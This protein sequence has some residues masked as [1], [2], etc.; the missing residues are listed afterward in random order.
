[1]IGDFASPAWLLLLPLAALPLLRRRGDVIDYPA[2]DW[3]PGSRKGL[4][5]DRIGRLLAALL[6]AAV[7]VG[8]AAPR[9][10]PTTV[11]RWARGAEIVIAFDRSSSMDDHL[12]NINRAGRNEL[13]DR[14]TK[15]EAVR[16]ALLDFIARRP[17]DRY[18]L[19]MFGTAPLRILPMTDDVAAIRAGLLATGIG[20]GLPRTDMG[21]VLKSAIAEFDDR[22]YAGSRAILLVSDGGAHLDAETRRAV[23]EG[24]QRN[25]IAL[26]FL[27]IRSSTHA[28][29]LQAIASRDRASGTAQGSTAQGGS[30]DTGGTGS[31]GSARGNGNDGADADDG[32]QTV[33]EFALHRFFQSL[34]T[35]YLVFQANDPAAIDAAIAEF[36]T[37]QNLPLLVQEQVP[38]L[39]YQRTFLLAAV[40]LCALL[41][42]FRAVKLEALR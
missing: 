32:T 26:Y 21:A 22:P 37:Q 29:D 18:A 2:V 3:L 9:Q 25:R 6:I 15:N 11:E 4:W 1:M 17:S 5:L 31:T 40:V 38:R 7:V 30:G 23:A 14:M 36:D 19:T 24:L 34:P 13:I 12:R 41:L 20:R 39:D 35:P 27:Y 28:P 33:A 42:T 16:T 10:G 8:L